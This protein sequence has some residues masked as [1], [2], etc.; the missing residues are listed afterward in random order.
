[1]LA[2]AKIASLHTGTNEPTGTG[3]VGSGTGFGHANLIYS[4]DVVRVG[5]RT[6]TVADG[7]CR[8]SLYDRATSNGL[9]YDAGATSTCD[10]TKSYQFGTT[11]GARL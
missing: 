11:S 3:S 5:V 8:G 7:Y 6:G 2:A 9:H 1:M 4:T 10:S